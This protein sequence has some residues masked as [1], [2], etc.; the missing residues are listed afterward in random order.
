MAS[1]SSR[2]ARRRLTSWNLPFGSDEWIQG[3]FSTGFH[4]PDYR[5]SRINRLSNRFDR[6]QELAPSEAGFSPSTPIPAANPSQSHFPKSFFCKWLQVE[7]AN[8]PTSCINLEPNLVLP[9][10]KPFKK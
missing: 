5:A 3:K 1:K 8:S 2:Q 4:G 10:L 6:L 9:C 7:Q